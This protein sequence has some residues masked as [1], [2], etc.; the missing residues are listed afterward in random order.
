MRILKLDFTW[1]KSTPLKV[2]TRMLHIVTNHHPLRQRELRG[3]AAPTPEEA[4]SI[5]QLTELLRD[6]I[7]A[8]QPLLQNVIVLSDSQEDSVAGVA[9]R[10]RVSE[11]ALESRL[12][13]T[14][15]GYAPAGYSVSRYHG[16]DIHSARRAD[17]PE[18]FTHL[19][20]LSAVQTP[21]GEI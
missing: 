19:R 9:N 6:V 20:C 2:L 15:A 3:T 5:G 4:F 17:R 11:F 12:L 7:A 14:R 21:D 10:L 1:T 18:V 16:R 8:L 13:S